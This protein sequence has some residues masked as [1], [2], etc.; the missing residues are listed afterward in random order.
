MT[1]RPT[2][3]TWYSFGQV[4]TYLQYLHR[5]IYNIYTKI[6]TLST[7][8]PGP[9]GDQV[10]VPGRGSAGDSAHLQGVCQVPGED[11][12]MSGCEK[13][14]R[15][16]LPASVG[17]LNREKAQVRGLLRDCETSLREG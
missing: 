4:S 8:C 10:Q 7:L 5:N 3:V 12:K 17:T 13:S 11:N 1:V 6:S 9:A 15:R 16:P 14:R 2:M